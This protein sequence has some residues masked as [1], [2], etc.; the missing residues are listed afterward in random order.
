MGSRVPLPQYN[1]RT[2]GSY[3]GGSLH[4][5]NAVDGPSGEIEGI[6]DVER[7]AITGGSLDNDEESTSVVSCLLPAPF[8]SPPTSFLPLISRFFCPEFCQGLKA[9]S[10]DYSYWKWRLT[11]KMM[12]FCSI[13]DTAAIF[14]R[15]Y[16]S[17]NFFS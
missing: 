5:L 3:I 4:D 9:F 7:D 1:L 12:N 10:S 15:F 13:N 17:P 16:L 14:P 11:F 6:S 8:L 2:A